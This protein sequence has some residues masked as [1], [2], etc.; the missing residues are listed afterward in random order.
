[1]RRVS[2]VEKKVCS[3]SMTNVGTSSAVLATTE[4][5]EDWQN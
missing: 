4:V 5:V 1:M 2:P 3:E